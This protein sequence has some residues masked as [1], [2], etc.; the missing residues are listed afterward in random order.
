[1]LRIA[2]R[3]IPIFLRL[4]AWLFA[5]PIRFAADRQVF[6]QATSQSSY[7]IGDC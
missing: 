6:L 3:R 7:A 2:M 1:M 5:Q 4:A